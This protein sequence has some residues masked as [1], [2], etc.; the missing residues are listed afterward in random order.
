MRV[1]VVSRRTI[2]PSQYHR[3]GL[4]YN[5][6]MYKRYVNKKNTCCVDGI[7]CI[8]IRTLGRYLYVC[9]ERGK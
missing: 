7:I 4:L 5:V 6:S 8:Y 3:H 9:I 1:A 2:T